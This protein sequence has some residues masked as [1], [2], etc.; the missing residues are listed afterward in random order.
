MNGIDKLQKDVVILAR[1]KEDLADYLASETLFYP[2]GPNYPELTL[3]GWLM[4]QHRLEALRDQ[5]GQDERNQ[6]EQILIEG[7]AILR[8]NIVRAEAK[9]HD[10][11][12][13][14]LRQWKTYLQDVQ[15]GESGAWYAT[16]VE[17]RAML[18]ALINQ[19]SNSPYQM[20]SDVPDRLEKVDMLA[21]FRW[22]SGD[23]VW[24]DGW[25]KAYP[26]ADFWYLY[27]RFG[28]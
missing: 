3:G 15:E 23:F 28:R 4:R 27:G 14:R 20:N 1:F 10:E 13:V 8:N 22:L 5:L 9:M 11:L 7:N 26:K 18:T 17:P 25:D 21:K 6:L 24:S 16:A 12:Q 2:T 19:L